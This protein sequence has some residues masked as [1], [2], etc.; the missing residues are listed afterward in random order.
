MPSTQHIKVCDCTPSGMESWTDNSGS[1][2]R[3]DNSGKT[4]LHWACANGNDKVVQVL[5]ECGALADAKDLTWR[6]TPI[7]MAARHG[8][9][10][11]LQ[12]LLSVSENID[13]TDRHGET[14]LFDSAKNNRIECVQLLI[15]AG[16]SVNH[17][18]KHGRSLLMSAVLWNRP[19][20]IKQLIWANCKME[21]KSPSSFYGNITGRLH[22]PLEAAV[23]EGSLDIAKMLVAGGS[24]ILTLDKF[25]YKPNDGKSKLM[26]FVDEES[27]GTWLEEVLSHPRTLK[28][29][30]RIEI[31][32]TM[33]S[34]NARYLF[35]LLPIPTSL[36]LYMYIPDIADAV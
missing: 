18:D 21:V 4:A 9:K 16:A 24:N 17:M 26:K 7:M 33:N 31:R 27:F 12:K 22:T 30:A 19:E 5:L 15:S 1:G 34:G 14:A 2:F 35:S 13:E 25:L 32:R 10:A 36:Q 20:V 23:M 11:I 3:T 8:H 28:E 29:L 6:L